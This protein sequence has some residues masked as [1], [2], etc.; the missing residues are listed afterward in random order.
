MKSKGYTL[1]EILITLTVVA[2]LAA[3]A[4]PSFNKTIQNT[5]IKTAALELLAAIEQARSTAVFNNTR[6]VL[7]AKS[8][9][10]SGWSLF[11]DA[12]NDGV[13]DSNEKLINEHA[14]LDAVII[15]GNHHVKNLISFISS[16]EGTVPAGKANSGTAMLGS[17][18]ICPAVD[19][20]N[21]YKIFLSKGGR[22]RIS[23]LS[24]AEC[25]QAR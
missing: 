5:R 17:I 20:A 13:Y 19:G 10:H 6:S 11:L 24:E 18:T 7:A 9:W 15:K 12:D 22:S 16:G 2:V 8:Q 23:E 1:P 3:S 21:G 14:P 25:K 4:I